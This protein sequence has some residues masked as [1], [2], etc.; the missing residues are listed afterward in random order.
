[1]AD[2]FYPLLTNSGKVR[3]ALV[4]FAPLGALVRVPGLE[5]VLLSKTCN[6]AG[7]TAVDVGCLTTK[8]IYYDLPLSKG[9]SVQL[10]SFPLFDLNDD[11]KAC[12]FSSINEMAEEAHSRSVKL[13]LGL[14]REFPLYVNARREYSG[15]KMTQGRIW[16]CA[17]LLP[18]KR[19]AVLGERVKTVHICSLVLIGP[20]P[21]VDP[22]QPF[23]HVIQV[24]KK[25]AQHVFGK[26]V[27]GAEQG[28]EL[29]FS[30]DKVWAFRPAI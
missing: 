30:W 15:D 12:A 17:H 20:A 10:K 21:D 28:T 27:E 3:N 4:K 26:V 13:P 7:F 25:D 5:G 8:K 24:T 18:D 19:V 6:R 9:A 22:A 23:T 11:E 2:K 1:M 29:K 16:C 14:Q